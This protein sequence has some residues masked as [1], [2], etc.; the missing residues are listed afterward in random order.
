MSLKDIW[1]TF[2]KSQY[3]YFYKD[4]IYQIATELEKI[5]QDIDKLHGETISL[6]SAIEIKDNKITE[7]NGEIDI[8]KK[9]LE[10]G[11]GEEAELFGA[12]INP[13][14]RKLL[15]PH[16][17]VVNLSDLNYGLTTVEEAK[18]FTKSTKVSVKEWKEESYDCDEFSFALMGYWN[19]GLYQYAFGIAWTKLHAFNIM[20]DNKKQIWIVEPQ[21]NMFY[22]IEDKKRD[23]NYYPME[24]IMI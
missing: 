18:R 19:L 24:I 23:V 4:E 1:K 6:K 10:D 7:L 17:K 9:L 12:I 21:T 16:S 14:L 5:N 22:K 20:V 11:I 13:N 15:I 2:I 3:E 8:L